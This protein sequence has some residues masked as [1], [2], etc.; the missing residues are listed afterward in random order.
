MILLIIS[1]LS[2]L[3]LLVA[4]KVANP[5]AY[6]HTCINVFLASSNV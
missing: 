2:I 6:N 1:L 3:I 5:L 4:T